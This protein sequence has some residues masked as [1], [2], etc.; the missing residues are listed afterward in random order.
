MAGRATCPDCCGGCVIATDDFNR[1]D[2]DD[3]G[4][5]WSEDGD[6][7]IDNEELL[8]STGG[9]VVMFQTDH[10]GGENA[11]RRVRVR[12]KMPAGGGNLV[13]YGSRTD[14]N[15]RVEAIVANNATCATILL[16]KY[17]SGVQTYLTPDGTANT[18]QVIG[19]GL[20]DD[21]WHTFDVCLDPAAY[22]Y[23]NGILRAKVTLSTG[24]VYGMEYEGSLAGSLKVG[25]QAS[26]DVRVDD[27]NFAWMRDEDDPDHD[28]CPNCIT[29]CAIESDSF[30]RAD[31]TDL[32]CKWSENSGIWQIVS[33]ELKMLSGGPGQVLCRVFHPG[34]K[35][36][37][38]VTCSAY[39]DATAQPM[40]LVNSKAD[41]SSYHWARLSWN[42]GSTLTITI[43]KDGTT[44]DSVTTSLTAAGFVTVTVCYSGSVITA[45]AGG[46][47]VYAISSAVSLGYYV[48]LAGN[49]SGGER[50]DDFVFKKHRDPDN[51]S[52]P[53]CPEAAITG[54]DCCDPGMQPP[55]VL[56]IDLGA[57]GWTKTSA[58]EVCGV[59]IDVC[60]QVFGEYG[61]EYAGNCCWEYHGPP[62]WDSGIFMEC[63]SA[64]LAIFACLIDVDATHCK[65]RVNVILHTH[66]RG[67]PC[68]C[69]FWGEQ[70]ESAPFVTGDTGADCRDINEILDF[71]AE[72][73]QAG[74]T[75]SW[76]D[77]R[78]PSS[79]N[80]FG[81]A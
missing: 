65:W 61:L 5:N 24:E 49:S 39:V 11:G 41:G 27:F 9:T 74:G 72:L 18:P 48:G 30:H 19:A 71:V 67:P 38:Y 34:Q 43:G 32:G 69:D 35:A 6:A 22:P 63:Y 57:G 66:D 10:P 23:V 25:M 44:L 2:N 59:D 52:C 40:I 13:L 78:L 17:E 81:A 42:G 29:P 20:P 31:T 26:Q 4:P 47:S 36:H 58:V 56:T 45:T 73:F 21:A 80:L 54:C 33:N 77:G 3:L 79:I 51:R 37:H 12:F 68:D 76:C 28:R 53:D 50:F 70:F 1:V 14:A 46:A 62:T 7:D 8:F 15:N 60:E 16:V 64:D 55:R 75:A